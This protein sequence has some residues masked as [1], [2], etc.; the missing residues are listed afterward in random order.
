M[1]MKH[2]CMWKWMHGGMRVRSVHCR[3]GS[4]QQCEG[5]PEAC[6]FSVHFKCEP[7]GIGCT[8]ARLLHAAGC[9]RCVRLQQAFYG[10]GMGDNT[11][12]P[13]R[14]GKNTETHYIP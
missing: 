12:T 2:T 8:W 4:E 7:Q 6:L 3:G 9:N 5:S 1:Q 13:T 14:G 11:Q 10:V